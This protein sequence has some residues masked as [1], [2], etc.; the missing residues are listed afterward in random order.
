MK[1]VFTQETISRQNGVFVYSMTFLLQLNFKTKWCV[2][3]F[4]D[5]TF[6]IQMSCHSNDDDDIHNNS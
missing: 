6:A 2:R 5:I 4:D 3:L 1:K